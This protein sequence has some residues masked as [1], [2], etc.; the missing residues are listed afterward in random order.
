MRCNLVGWVERPAPRVD[1]HLHGS[2]G[3]ETHRSERGAIDGFRRA[4]R[5]EDIAERASSARLNPS[6]VRSGSYPRRVHPD[7]VDARARRDIERLLVGIAE[8][9]IGAFGIR[10]LST[11]G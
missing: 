6:Y 8:A 3:H 9:H 7:L 5:R 4:L 10:Y 1:A 2:L 11:L